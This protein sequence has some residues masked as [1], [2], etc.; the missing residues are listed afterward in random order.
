MLIGAP[1]N[2]RLKSAFIKAQNI[3]HKMPC[4]HEFIKE[5]EAE[6]FAENLKKEIGAHH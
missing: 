4:N 5:D 3:M 2:E 6:A 1:Q